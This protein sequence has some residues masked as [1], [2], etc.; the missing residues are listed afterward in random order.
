MGSQA[1]CNIKLIKM[2]GYNVLFILVFCNL[3][4]D[5]NVINSIPA[6]NMGQDFPTKPATFYISRCFVLC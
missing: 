6:H 2:K 5:S 4:I 3:V 1:P